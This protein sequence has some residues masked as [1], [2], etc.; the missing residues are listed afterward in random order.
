M[1]HFQH[2]TSAWKHSRGL[3]LEQD[4]V[5]QVICGDGLN[6]EGSKGE[7]AI[8]FD[9]IY[10]GAAIERHDLPKIA[11]LLRTGGVMVGPGRPD[12]VSL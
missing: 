4:P 12:Q 2:A 1:A 5:L 8:G 9:R 6:I 7:A 3:L 10:I 11:N